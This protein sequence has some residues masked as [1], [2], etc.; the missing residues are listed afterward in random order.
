MCL[1]GSQESLTDMLV[2]III[3]TTHYFVTFLYI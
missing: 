3:K 1:A 2:T